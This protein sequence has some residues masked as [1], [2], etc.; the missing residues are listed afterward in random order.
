MKTSGAGELLKVG[1]ATVRK[2]QDD[3]RLSLC[4][5]PQSNRRRVLVK[6]V[7]EIIA[8]QLIKRELSSAKQ[9]LSKPKIIEPK[10]IRPRGIKRNSS[11]YRGVCLHA[12]SGLFR[13][14]IQVGGKTTYLGYFKNEIEA[15]K[16]YNEAAIKYHG[17][18]AKLNPL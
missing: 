16:A 3:G 14:K 5:L 6:E 13:A 9:I 15:A 1:Q 8:D 10:I 2:M 7:Y 18:F 17:E 12:A 11:K 4:F